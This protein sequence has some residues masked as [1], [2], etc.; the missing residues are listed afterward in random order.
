LGL[1]ASRLRCSDLR[2]DSCVTLYSFAELA[3]PDRERFELH[4]LSCKACWHEVERLCAAAQVL[5]TSPGVMRRLRT[6]EVVGQF[7]MSGHLNR[8]FAGHVAFALLIAGLY[9][10]LHTA[11]VW[12]ELAYSYDRF[13]M[14]GWILSAGVFAWVMGSLCGALWVAATVV[15]KGDYRALSKATLLL[16]GMLAI[17]TA[18]MWRLLPATPTIEATFATRSAAAGF[19]KNEVLYFLP[20]LLFVLPTFHAVAA[21]QAELRAGRFCAVLDLLSGSREAVVPRGV[22]LVPNWFLS[23]VLVVAALI[24]YVGTNNLL[25]NLK[26]GAYS[27]TFT[28]ALYIRVFLWYVL[29]VVCLVWYQRSI[30][31]L[32][33]EAIAASRLVGGER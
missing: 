24:G 5:K 11:S 28:A 21:L 14:L 17:M 15:L 8:P 30:Q 25:D 18:A 19:L 31:E 33:R 2:F 27:N 16:I 7:G 22:W 9:A 13:A 23:V 1:P 20:L 6:P 32:K 29:A 12:T 3:G 10:S 4:L 26:E